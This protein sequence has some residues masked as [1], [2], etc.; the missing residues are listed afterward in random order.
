MAKV[1]ITMLRSAAGPHGVLRKGGT[2][3]VDEQT[4]ASFERVGICKVKVTERPP[5]AAAKEQPKEE[6]K[7][8]RKRST[9]KKR[10]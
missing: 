5:A 2:Y 1:K 8:T 10:S 6:P 9:R 4:A 7:T 3:E